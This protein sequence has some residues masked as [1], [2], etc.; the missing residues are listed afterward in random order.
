[1]YGYLKLNRLFDYK[2]N[3]Y[4]FSCYFASAKCNLFLV[5]VSVNL[6]KN[7]LKF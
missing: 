4:M 6:V 1:M 2:F 5:F 3:E 7:S